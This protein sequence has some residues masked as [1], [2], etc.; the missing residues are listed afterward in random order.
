MT[1]LKTLLAAESWADRDHFL[2]TPDGDLPVSVLVDG[3]TSLRWGAVHATQIRL[4]GEVMSASQ[5][6]NYVEMVAK[7][8]AALALPDDFGSADSIEQVIERLPWFTETEREFILIWDTL[9]PQEA[10]DWRWHKNGTYLGDQRP[11]YEHLGDEKH[12][13]QIVT[14]QAVEVGREPVIDCHRCLVAAHIDEHTRAGDLDRPFTDCARC[15]EIR[16]R[17]ASARHSAASPYGEGMSQGS[18]R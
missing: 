2:R 5:A 11:Q 12:I 13:V 14:W 9:T 10:P 7:R 16:A 15:D 6:E 1:I 4:W 17:G 8:E 18:G 3:V